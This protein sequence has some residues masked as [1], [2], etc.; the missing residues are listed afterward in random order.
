[1]T[2][3]EVGKLYI[4]LQGP[5]VGWLRK[6]GRT[7]QQAEDIVQDAF[8]YLLETKDKRTGLAITPRYRRH[9]PEQGESLLRDRIRGAWK[10]QL[11]HEACYEEISWDE[12]LEEEIEKA[13]TRGIIPRKIK[14]IAS[15]NDVEENLAVNG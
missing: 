10:T 5:M 8:C 12:V 3:D 7:L 15:S 11:K 2:R 1:M 13:H 4:K 6:R 9:A 14:P